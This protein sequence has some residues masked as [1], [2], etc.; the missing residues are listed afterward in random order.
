[1]RTHA[2]HYTKE[3]FAQD[4]IG[5]DHRDG[6]RRSNAT[7]KMREALTG[8]DETQREE[9]SFQRDQGFDHND[10]VKPAG[11]PT[12]VEKRTRPLEAKVSRN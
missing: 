3:T 10:G 5:S 8:L 12:W 4:R 6:G 1:M 7:I 11:A 9:R 2:Q